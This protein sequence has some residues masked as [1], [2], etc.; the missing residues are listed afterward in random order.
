MLSEGG[1]FSLT[2]ML[3]SKVS[4]VKDKEDFIACWRAMQRYESNFRPSFLP[5][6]DLALVHEWLASY[7]FKVVADVVE[8][9]RF[10][11][12]H[13]RS[14]DREG[15][16]NPPFELMH[17]LLVATRSPGDDRDGGPRGRSITHPRESG[18]GHGHGNDH[19]RTRG[20]RQLPPPADRDRGA[21]A[22]LG[23]SKGDPSKKRKLSDKHEAVCRDSNPRL[24]IPWQRGACKK[25]GAGE[26]HTVKP[27]RDAAPA[28]DVVHRCAECNATDHGCL[29]CRQ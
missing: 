15:L 25:A 17:K 3:N 21:G 29:Q 8:T 24:C 18:A 27:Y 7:D 14:Y 9:L 26:A 16:Y 13:Q 6:R 10:H 2:Q 28:F 5:P 4:A 22:G 12:M 19:R 20:K 1:K 11:R 23:T